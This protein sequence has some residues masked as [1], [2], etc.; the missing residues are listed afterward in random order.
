[1]SLTTGWV[2]GSCA[3]GGPFLAITHDGGLTWQSQVLSGTEGV[4]YQSPSTSLPTFFSARDGYLV[5]F[6][7]TGSVLYTTADGGQSWAPHTLPQPPGGLTP[8]VFFQSPD[9]GWIISQDGS[10]VY[11][12]T[13]G[14]LHWTTY[15]PTPALKEVGS[16]DFIDPQRGLAEAISS[17]NQSVLLQTTDGGRTWQQ[18]AP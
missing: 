1:V 11:Q 17:N 6:Q 15:R 10:V 5:F 16:V 4:L 12:T 8:T 7:A 13:D 18:I 9:N 14:G 2:T 3:A